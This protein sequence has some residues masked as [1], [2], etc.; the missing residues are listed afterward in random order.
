MPEMEDA[1]IPDKRTTR[2]V[3]VRLNKISLTHNTVPE[4]RDRST[5]PDTKEETT[6]PPDN[7]AG[8]MT[9]P[10]NKQGQ[11]IRREAYMTR[12]ATKNRGM[13]LRNRQLESGSQQYT[14]QHTENQQTSQKIE[15]RK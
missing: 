6:T 2:Q 10:R 14:R 15:M 3:E 11:Q 1:A 9:T 13:E 5:T 8:R 12:S 7:T 4:E